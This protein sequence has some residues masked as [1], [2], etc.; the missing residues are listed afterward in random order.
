MEVSSRLMI[1]VAFSPLRRFSPDFFTV[2]RWRSGHALSKFSIAGVSIS[3]TFGQIQKSI[4]NIFTK[5][6]GQGNR[7]KCEVRC[8]F[9]TRPAT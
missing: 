6:A 5:S 2:P 7:R 9:F 1:A 4:A 8:E 3:K